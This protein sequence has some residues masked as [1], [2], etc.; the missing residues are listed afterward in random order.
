MQF[1]AKKIGTKLGILANKDENLVKN[2]IKDIAQF[3]FSSGKTSKLGEVIRHFSNSYNKESNTMDL[4]VTAVSKD[5]IPSI[6]ELAGKKVNLR[7][8]IDTSLLG[9]IKIEAEGMLV[10]GSIKRKIQKLKALA[11]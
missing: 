11:K 8:K 1:S 9:G 5:N 6:K 4:L 2:S 7:E 10:D 3:I